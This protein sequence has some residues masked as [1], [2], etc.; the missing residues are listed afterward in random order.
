MSSGRAETGKRKRRRGSNRPR[1]G[2]HARVI[3]RFGSAGDAVYILVMVGFTSGTTGLMAAALR[4]PLIFP[5]LGPSIFLLFERP[6]EPEAS[7]RNMLFGHGVALV[8]GAVAYWVFGLHRQSLGTLPRFSGAAV[9]AASVS[10]AVTEALL[11]LLRAP[12]PP[13]GATALIVSMGMLSSANDLLFLAGGVVLVACLALV[14][15]R[16]LG[17]PVPLWAPV[18]PEASTDAGGDHPVDHA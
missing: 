8:I 3:Q 7:P 15:N 14:L 13:A 10:L 2:V 16:A 12:H 4:R 9:A 17:I 6:M 11:V 1:F 5:S 18:T